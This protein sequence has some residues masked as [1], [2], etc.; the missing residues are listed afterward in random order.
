MSASAVIAPPGGLSVTL[1]GRRG[2]GRMTRDHARRRGHG[3]MKNE[4][5]PTTKPQRERE[6]AGIKVRTRL[7]AGI[8]SDATGHFDFRPRFLPT[9]PNE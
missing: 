8:W 5:A 1:A 7:R 3:R 4:T 6:R 2:A 9:I